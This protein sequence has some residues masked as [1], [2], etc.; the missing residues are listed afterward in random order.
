MGQMSLDTFYTKRFD[1]ATGILCAIREKTMVLYEMPFYKPFRTHLK[2]AG[3]TQ[4][5]DVFSF[6]PS[7]RIKVIRNL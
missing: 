2:M 1:L 3:K 7:M 4:M 6:Y 5:Y